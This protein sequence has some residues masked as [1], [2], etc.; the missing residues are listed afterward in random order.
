VKRAL[1]HKQEKFCVEYLIDFNATQAAI[2]A[3]YSPR[4]AKEIGYENLTKPHLQDRIAE[5]QL[6]NIDASKKGDIAT[7]E[8]ILRALTMDHRFNPKRLF[9]ENGEMLPIP[10]LPDEIALS[11]A[12]YEVVKTYRKGEDGEFEPQYR[13]KYKFPDKSRVRDLMAKL[14]ES[15]WG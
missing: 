3:E 4:T 11:L 15:S 7:P 1:S 13:H 2:R 8:E 10:E 12:G 9:D 14:M 5:L 6:Q